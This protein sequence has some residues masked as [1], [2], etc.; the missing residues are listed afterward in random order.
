MKKEVFIAIVIGF[1]LGLLITFGIWTAN[2]ALKTQSEAPTE[3]TK[4]ETVVEPTPTPTG[5]TLTILSPEDDALID[6]SKTELK[7]S[8]VA[9]AVIVIVAEKEEKIIEADENGSFATEV[10]LIRGINE[11]TITAFNQ[12][13]EKT[14]QTLNVVYSTAEI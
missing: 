2:K 1:A 5:F 12:E 3:E 8:S 6:T 13:G 14:S 10:S 11:I 7:G 4:T 9:Q